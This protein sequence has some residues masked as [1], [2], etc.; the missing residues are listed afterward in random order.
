MQNKILAIIPARGGSKSVPKKNIKKLDG[1]PLI[2]YS[3]DSAKESKLVNKIIVSTDSLEISKLSKK[4]GVEV[5]FLRPKKL[6]LDSSATIDVIKH[7]VK[8]L[9]SLHYIPDIIT[10]L[11][12]TTPLRTSKMIDDS[13]KLLIKTKS[14]CVLGVCKLSKHPYRAFWPNGKYLKPFRNDFLK[15][16]Q[17]QLFPTCYYPTGEIYTFWFSTLKKTGNLYGSKIFPFYLKNHISMDI[18]TKLDF[19][20]TEM[21]LKNRKISKWFQGLP[22]KLM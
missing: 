19:F 1:K 18:N 5:P 3:I 14:T 20:L 21:M 15:F 16:H 11:Q 10:L 22:N 17:R 8:K 13:I 4:N 6:S 2:Q 12:P 7:A 9:E